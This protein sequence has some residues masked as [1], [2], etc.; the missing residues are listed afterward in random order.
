MLAFATTS[1]GS[2]SGVTGTPQKFVGEVVEGREVLVEPG[3]THGP[4][5]VTLDG[6]NI[7]D[8]GAVV[9]FTTINRYGQEITSGDVMLSNL[10]GI[11]HDDDRDRGVTL[12]SFPN[13]T[14]SATTI[15]FLLPSSE[16]SATLAVFDAAGREVA[17]PIDSQ[18]LGLGTHAVYF[19]T[20]DLASGSY[21][22]RLTT[23][24]GVTSTV[25]KVIR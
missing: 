22:A 11:A 1:N 13:P 5:Y 21:Y 19:N 16:S 10:S 24:H 15:E 7:E 6:V 20:S 9:R 8:T 23:S 12:V 2:D 4:I 18:A 17:R 25:V 3:A 14:H